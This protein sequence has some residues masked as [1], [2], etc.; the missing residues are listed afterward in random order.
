MTGELEPS[1]PMLLGLSKNVTAPM[2][3]SPKMHYFWT[4]QLAPVNIFRSSSN[5]TPSTH[6]IQNY[7]F[8]RPQ[9]SFYS[10]EWLDL[11]YEA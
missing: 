8:S 2:L 4:I 1:K 6:A 10:V 5:I 3:D 11:L 7:S 9:I